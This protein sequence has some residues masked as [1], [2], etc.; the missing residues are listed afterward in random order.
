MRAVLKGALG[1]FGL[2]VRR[3]DAVNRFDAMPQVLDRLARTGFSPSVIVDVGANVGGWARA[4]RAAF[5]AARIHAVEPQARLHDRLQRVADEL[6]DMVVHR[7][8]ATA[9]GVSSVHLAGG[10]DGDS[11]GAWV[12]AAVNDHLTEAAPAATLDAM[13]DGACSDTDTLMLKL[14]VEGHELTVLD[15]AARLLS[16]TALIV[17]EV[18]YYD[19]NRDG[20]P[21]LKDVVAYM[22]Q[23]GFELFDVVGLAERPRDGR[24]RSGDV[25][26]VH[27]DHPLATDVAWA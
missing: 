23:R 5:P 19:V 16:R 26:F 7:V 25:V 24:L 13:L 8:A 21:L 11:T 3:L 6:G 12:T 20:H 4:A 2:A 17:C 1:V 9:P 22:D 10:D 15:G 27:R 14:D 18:A